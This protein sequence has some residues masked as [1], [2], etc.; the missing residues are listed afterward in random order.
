MEQDIGDILNG[1]EVEIEAKPETVEEE[2]KTEERPRDEHGRFLPKGDDEPEPAAAQ[3]EQPSA[4]PAPS[5][6]ESPTV[7]RTALQDERRKRQT[8]EAEL[9]DLNQRFMQVQQP[10]AAQQPQQI[11]DQWEDPDGHTRYLAEQAAQ[12]AEE[13]AFQRMQQH[14]VMVS[15]EAA[16]TKHPDYL[17]RIAVFEQLSAQNPA[18]SQQM[19]NHPDPAEYA[20]SIAQQHEKMSQYGSIDEMLA[21]EKVKWEAEALAKLKAELPAQPAPA[22]LANERNVGSRSGPA[23]SG[24]ASMDE[25][26]SG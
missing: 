15:A 4:P 18:L 24:P 25:M 22:S 8:L 12:V 11:P 1:E 3:P 17:D 10:P 14:R 23:W 19:L 16:K 20:Y 7:P 26:L 5:E 9:A 21:A 13:R 2:V 6:D